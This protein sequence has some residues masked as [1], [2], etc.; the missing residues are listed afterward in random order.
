MSKQTKILYLITKANWGG[1]QRYVYDLATNLPT[2]HEPV[3]VVG[4]DGML[5][6]LLQDAGIR[7]IS[8]PSLQRNVSL[9]KDL[10]VFLALFRIMRRERP[11]VVHVN[12]SK[13][14]GIGACVGRLLRVDR[15]IYTSHGWSFN[16]DRPV[17]QK[18]V[19]KFLHWLTILFSHQTIA[20]SEGLRSQFT[21]PGVQKKLTVIHPGR[22]LIEL[23]YREEA[24]GILETKIQGATANLHD[25]HADVWI[26]SIAELHKTKQLHRAIDSM[27]ALTKTLPNLRLLLIHD[28][29]ERSRLEQQ[30]KDLGL[31]Q[32]VYFTGTIPDAARLLPAFDVFVLPSLSEAFGYV[33]VEAGLA[34]VP[35]VATRV[36][37][38]TDILTDEETAVLVE[39]GNT[40]A[41]T[42]ALRR[43][44]EDKQLRH[45]LAQANYDNVQRFSLATMLHQ[46]LRVY[47]D[48]SSMIES[49]ED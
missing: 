32:H 43:L 22:T 36:G 38:V 3:V 12:S 35:I 15:I 44:I 41:L 6:A 20:V 19:L 46:T 31:E 23:K 37:G 7:T 17:W 39:A 40:P 14:G 4:G 2:D 24:R 25:Y 45:T 48:H 34:T 47:T 9:T 5:T 30:V 8:V 49:S 13:A 42:A 16:E 21:W 27:A 11:D 33:L 1:A 18:L 29:D 26:G 10:R 28:G